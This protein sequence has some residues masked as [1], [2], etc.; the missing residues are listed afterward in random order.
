MEGLMALCD[1][2]KATSTLKELKCDPDSNPYQVQ[3]LG[4]KA[5]SSH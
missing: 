2:L 1:A 4:P 5:V 3:I